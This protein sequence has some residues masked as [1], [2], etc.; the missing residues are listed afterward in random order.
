MKLDNFPKFR[1][2]IQS[3]PFWLK[4][5]THGILEVL[6]PNPDLIFWNFYPEINFW[7]NLSQKNKK[8]LFY[9]KIGT[10]CISRCWFS[11]FRILKPFLGKFWPKNLKL[12]VLPESWHT[13]YLQY[14]DY[15]SDIS[16]R[17]FQ[18]LISRMLIF[19]LTLVFWNFKPKFIF[20]ANLCQKSRIFYFAWKLKNRVSRGCDCKDTEEGLET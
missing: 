18:T 2:K 20:W 8:C 7:T 17:K 3:C 1:P 4:I 16:F 5:G 15:Y 10:H 9:L 13:E 6:I 12:S 11:E 19:I 14:V